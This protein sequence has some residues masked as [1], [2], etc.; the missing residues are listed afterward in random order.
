MQIVKYELLKKNYY[1]IYLSKGEV[2]TL[3]D[4][5]I[6]DNE[7]LL[8]KEIDK[9]L[10]DKLLYDNKIYEYMEI[11]IKYISV[12]LRSIKEIRDYLIKKGASESESD[13]ATNELIRLG[14]LD[15]NTFAKAFIKDKLNF[16][17]MGDYKLK[18]ELERLGIDNSII[19][20][21]LNN[22]ENNIYEERMKKIIEKD[23][24]TNKK[25][26]GI[27][28]KNKIYN[29]LLSQG[30]SKERVITIINKYNF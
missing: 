17:N 7:L 25:Y 15:D 22:I 11:G 2:I 14:Y 10:Y 5:V 13:K 20:E 29:H 28:L 18:K 21:N 9:E 12:R 8:K 26:N 6:T 16:T 27:K 30:Y 23:I 24:R 1:N 4:K 19:E 3:S